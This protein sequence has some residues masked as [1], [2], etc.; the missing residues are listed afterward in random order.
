MASDKD[1]MAVDRRKVLAQLVELRDE[2]KRQGNRDARL[3]AED[4]IKEAR[5]AKTEDD[6]L[7]LQTATHYIDEMLN[8]RPGAKDKMVVEDRFYFGK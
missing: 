4:H 8:S 3:T 6:W 1:K 5:L 2:A 7:D